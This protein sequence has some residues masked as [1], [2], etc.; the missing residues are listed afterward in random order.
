MCCS[1]FEAYRFL[2]ELCNCDG[3]RIMPGCTCRCARTCIGSTTCEQAP[4]CRL[5]RKLLWMANTAMAASQQTGVQRGWCSSS[6]SCLWQSLGSSQIT[7][8][9]EYPGDICTTSAPFYSEDGFKR[10][11][12]SQSYQSSAFDGSFNLAKHV[13]L[14]RARRLILL[15]PH[16]SASTPA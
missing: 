3:A 8:G 13:R 1:E 9:K 15:I 5:P 7:R 11:L 12:R 16:L 10:V 6:G 14:N 4:S 2:H